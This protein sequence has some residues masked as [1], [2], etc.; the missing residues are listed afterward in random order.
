MTEQLTNQTFD[1]FNNPE[2]PIDN[3]TKGALNVLEWAYQH[4]SEEELI[5]ACSFGI[6]GIVLIDLISKVNDYAKVV[7]L[8]TSL[9]FAET[10]QLIEQV[11]QKYPDLRI[12]M[13]KPSLT[14]EEQAKK[15]GDGLWKEK[16]ISAA[17][18]ARLFLLTKCSL[19]LQRGCQDYAENKV[20]REKI[21]S[22]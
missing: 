15:H 3:E 21:P 19:E 17:K 9:H 7:F 2:F 5:Y 18:F 13:K 4:Y 8:D 14:L 10:Y 1:Q 6:E 11:K 12:E 22:S 20:K 16:R